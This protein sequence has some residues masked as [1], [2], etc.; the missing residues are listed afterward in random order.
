MLT[1][2]TQPRA[3]ANFTVTQARRVYVVFA[4]A[5][6]GVLVVALA[7]WRWIWRICLA[8]STRSSVFGCRGDIY[9]GFYL[10]IF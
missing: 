10:L 4:V 1:L 8:I 3:S 9:L 5:D 7:F 2:G 6:F